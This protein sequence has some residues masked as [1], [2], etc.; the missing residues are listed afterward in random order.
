VEAER[1]NAWVDAN[2]DC[3]DSLSAKIARVRKKKAAAKAPPMRNLGISLD[4]NQKVAGDNWPPGVEL[5]RALKLA[6]AFAQGEK[7]PEKLIRPS[8]QGSTRATLQRNKPL[9]PAYMRRPMTSMA[10]DVG[11]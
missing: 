6:T 3:E 10:K 11:Y 2:Q 9:T 7:S 8:S 4:I 5:D 1:R